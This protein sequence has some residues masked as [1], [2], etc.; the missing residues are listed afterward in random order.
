MDIYRFRYF[1]RKL[2]FNLPPLENI[3]SCPWKR[4]T[5]QSL[6]YEWMLYRDLVGFYSIAKPREKLDRETKTLSLK[7]FP[8]A[9]IYFRQV[10]IYIISS[11][12]FNFYPGNI[13]RGA[14]IT[15]VK[16]KG[17]VFIFGQ[18]GR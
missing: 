9:A 11:L 4:C 8:W 14:I 12:L 6:V 1:L 7:S 16:T 13:S 3:G 10:G 17:N 5:D 18:F 15:P 2:S